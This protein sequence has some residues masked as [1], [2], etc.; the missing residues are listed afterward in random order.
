MKKLEIVSRFLHNFQEF[1]IQS[2][3]IVGWLFHIC[4]AAY[5]Q[6][7][8]VCFTVDRQFFRAVDPQ[9]SVIYLTIVRYNFQ[10]RQAILSQFSFLFHNCQ[11]VFRE[12]SGGLYTISRIFLHSRLI[13]QWL[14]ANFQAII[15]KLVLLHNC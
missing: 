11:A 9:M 2:V 14:V 5:E 8:V 3:T 12:F 15:V 10:A 4:Q 1:V 6:F 13:A 7:T